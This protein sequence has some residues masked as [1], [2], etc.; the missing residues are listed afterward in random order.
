MPQHRI[1]K[2][3]RKTSSTDRRKQLADRIDLLGIITMAPCPQCSSSGSLCVIQKGC[4]RCSACLRRNVRCDGTFSAAEFDALEA[5]KTE[6][7]RKKVEA[8]SKLRSL[9]WEILSTQQEHDELER[10]WKQILS[11]QEGMVEQEARALDELDGL[12]SPGLPDPQVSIMSSVDFSAGA[13]ESLPG[14]NSPQVT[15][16]G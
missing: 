11:R 4:T 13:P 16:H 5:R 14:G 10:Q 3:P 12:L 9:A 8:R 2:P 1:S 6:I 15:G 7:L